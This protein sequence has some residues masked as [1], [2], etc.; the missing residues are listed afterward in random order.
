MTEETRRRLVDDR[1][2]ELA[3]NWLRD[4]AAAIGK[5]KEQA[6]LT[7]KM[8]KHIRAIEMKK[9]G[10]LPVSAQERDA[11]ASDA[12]KMAI[13]AEAVAAGEHEKMRALREAASAKVD[14]WRSEQANLRVMR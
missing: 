10:D 9:A 12:Y 5:A 1:E 13:Y 7:E 2:V 3:M 14:L 4:N 11:Q 8:V 6:V